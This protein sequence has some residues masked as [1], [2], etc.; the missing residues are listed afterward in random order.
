MDHFPIFKQ[1]IAL[2][3][4]K[5]IRLFRAEIWINLKMQKKIYIY[6]LFE[7]VSIANIRNET[8]QVIGNYSTIGW[9]DPLPTAYT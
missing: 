7:Y 3:N 9:S 1:I 8:W 6:M 2:S 5:S 4:K